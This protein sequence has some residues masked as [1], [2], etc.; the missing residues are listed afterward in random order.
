MSYFSI[1]KNIGFWVVGLIL[2]FCVPSMAGAQDS[3][4]KSQIRAAEQQINTKNEQ[5]KRE[6]TMG[7][8]NA[9]I[10][11][12]LF[13][14]SDCSACV[15]ADRMLYDAMKDENVIGLSCYINDRA[16]YID[17]QDY[18]TLNSPT[19][20]PVDKCVFRQWTYLTGSRMIDSY[21]NTPEFVIGGSQ[22][23]STGNLSLFES[24]I[25]EQSYIP[26][27]QTLPVKMEWLSEYEIGITLPEKI[28]LTARTTNA[29]V[30][31]IRYKNMMIEK[32]ESGP[33]AGKVLRFS[34][35]IQDIRHIGKWYGKER[36]IKINVNRPTDIKD[37][38]GYVV[39]VQNMLGEPILAAGRLSDPAP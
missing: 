2:G 36:M 9:P 35:I 37:R 17:K 20:G 30:W 31:I 12:E 24:M 29:G 27:N 16:S 26:Y 33:N 28:S 38:G 6:S 21:L 10:V 23:L 1:Q 14:A 8:T 11:I 34:N 3:D 7:K 19:P 5:R 22:K 39:F 13:T 15:Y 4:L 32:V 25:K 18:R